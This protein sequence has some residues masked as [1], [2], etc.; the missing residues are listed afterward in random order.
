MLTYA[1]LPNKRLDYVL[2]DC[3]SCPRIWYPAHL[4]HF[5]CRT[6]ATVPPELVLLPRWCYVNLYAMSSW[7]RTIVVPLSLVWAHKPVR[8]LPDELGIRELFLGPPDAPAWP[9]PLAP[10]RL[11]WTNF[12]LRSEERRVGK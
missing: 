7:T 1:T 2:D 9:C 10:Q 12:F 11:S 3:L 8:P 5:P 6:C 4:V